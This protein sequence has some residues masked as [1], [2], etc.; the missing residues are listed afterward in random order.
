M[1]THLVVNQTE[2]AIL[3]DRPVE[4]LDDAL[5]WASAADI[6]LQMDVKNVVVTLGAKGAYYAD[7]IGDK[8]HVKAEKDINVLDV[9][10]LGIAILFLSFSGLFYL[11]Q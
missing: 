4:D 2:A 1:I 6:F 10:G 7:G 9:T 3:A 11:L 8:G 5:G